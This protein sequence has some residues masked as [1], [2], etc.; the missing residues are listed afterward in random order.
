MRQTE[1]SEILPHSREHQQPQELEG[2]RMDSPLE[3]LEE[4]GPADMSTSQPWDFWPPD[5]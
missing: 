1:V 5:Q 2:A 4:R 3:P